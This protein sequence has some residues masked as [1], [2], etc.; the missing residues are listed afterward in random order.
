[1]FEIGQLSTNYGGG[2]VLE[3]LG[4]RLVRARGRDE[5]LFFVQVSA[6]QAL[7]E[8]VRTLDQLDF[9]SISSD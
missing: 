6:E 1:M 8:Q 7:L 4:F 9:N 5:S 3:N 2:Q